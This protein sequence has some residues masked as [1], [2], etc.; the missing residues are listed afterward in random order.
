MTELTADRSLADSIRAFVQDGWRLTFR[1][2]NVAQL[3][4]PKRVDV[5]LI[6]FPL[7][8]VLV[9][10]ATREGQAYLE[11]NGATT[12]CVVDED[13]VPWLGGTVA[14]FLAFAQIIAIISFLSFVYSS[15]T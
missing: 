9:W 6:L 5:W 1:D 15:P 14:I 4:R 2:R 7:A 3:V 11:E 13:G 10:L 8:Y 12:E